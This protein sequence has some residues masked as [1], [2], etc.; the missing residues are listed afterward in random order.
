ML[1]TQGGLSLLSATLAGAGLVWAATAALSGRLSIGDV[2]IFVAAVAG[3]QGS[4]AGAVRNLSVIHEALLMFGHYRA[5][6]ATPPDL[7]VPADPRPVPPL[8]RGIEFRDVWFR[9]GDD[10]PWILRGVDLTIGFGTAAALVGENGA[11]KSTM[12]KLLCRLYDPTRGRVLWDGVDLREFDPASLRER[13]STVF[14][15]YTCYDLSARENIALGDLSAIDDQ[16]RLT[17]AARRAGA[18]DAVSRLPK[19][20]DTLLSR[21]FRDPDADDPK[22]GVLLSGGQW[23]RLALA[24]AFLRDQRDLL[25]L[26]EPSSGLDAE[27]EYEIHARLRAHRQGQ[28]SLLISHR[29][30]TLRDASQIAV[31]DGGRITELGDHQELLAAGGTYARL[32]ALQSTGYR[33]AD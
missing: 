12:V 20:Y 30:G 19:G 31:L 32:F 29:L 23:Q 11:G 28:T 25:I 10:Q 21:M 8:R 22:G 6:I 27:A 33:D 7:P 4:L 9:Y 17:A 18:H 24:R 2:A 14:Q 15:D 1:G 13:M 5:V 26:D 16:P 3:T